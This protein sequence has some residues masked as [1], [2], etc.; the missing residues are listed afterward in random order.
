MLSAL[1]LGFAGG[2]MLDLKAVLVFCGVMA[3]CA[4]ASALVC[5]LWPGFDGAGWKLWLV[6]VIA[7]P[8]FLTA[9]FFAYQDRDCLIGAKTGW[10]CMF[11]QAFPLGMAICL[12]PPPVGLTLRWLAR[13]RSA[14]GK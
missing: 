5:R 6:G 14:A 3:G 12:V 2:A 4:L 11:S 9:T 13:R 8:L 1:L 7:N 10:D